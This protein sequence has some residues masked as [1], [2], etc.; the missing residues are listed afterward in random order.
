M[1]A[2]QQIVF[3]CTLY[4]LKLLA[5]QIPQG[6]IETIWTWLYKQYPNYPYWAIRF[7]YQ[8]RKKRTNM[9]TKEGSII[10]RNAN[11]CEKRKVG[12]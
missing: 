1:L 9:F 4:F 11:C 6:Y 8:V 7:S 10:P 3:L 5:K 12:V 2:E